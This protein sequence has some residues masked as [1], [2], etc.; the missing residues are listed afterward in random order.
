MYLTIASNSYTIDIHARTIL[1]LPRRSIIASKFG[2]LVP[3]FGI[4]SCV[5]TITNWLSVRLPYGDI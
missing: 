4:L 5:Y 3:I 1:C 2:D